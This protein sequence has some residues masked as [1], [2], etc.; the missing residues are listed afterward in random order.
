MVIP[1][2]DHNP[3]L[4]RAW[5]TWLLV[6]ANIA[7]FVLFEPVS[8][9]DCQQR[10]FFLRWAAI[11]TELLQGRPLSPRQ[12]AAATA[13]ACPISVFSGK[14]VY[15]S[16]LYSM[17]LHGDWLHLLGNMLYLGIF[18]NNVEDRFGHLRFL[19]FYLLSGLVATFVFVGVNGMDLSTL[20][21][22]SGAIAGVL[23]AYL[24]LF[25]GARVTSLLFIFPIELPALIVLGLWFV[26]QIDSLRV[27]PMAGGGVAYL[28]H[29][30]GFLFG[31]ICTLAYRLANPR[32]PRPVSRYPY[33]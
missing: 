3:T 27:A 1:I 31:A 32:R 29:V 22:A 4:R 7:V 17:F 10:A 13:G 15:L 14:N 6:A 24:V 8:G 28:A 30:A 21:G 33:L 9:T 11:P 25:P 2:G 12:I 5:V 19:A 20:I 23:G 26:L 16:P 18:G